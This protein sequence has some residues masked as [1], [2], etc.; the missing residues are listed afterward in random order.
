[1]VRGLQEVTGQESYRLHPQKLSLEGKTDLEAD[2]YMCFSVV[3]EAPVLISKIQIKD[4]L[5]PLLKTIPGPPSH[6]VK[7]EVLT[8]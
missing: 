2:N 8:Q 6:G 1:M 5:T 4:L 3:Q 7:P